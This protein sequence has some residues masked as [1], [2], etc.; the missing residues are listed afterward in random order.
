[1]TD[2]LYNLVIVAHPDDETIYFTAPILKDKTHPWRVICI[3]N[4]NAD[5]NG[6]S[7]SKQFED[8]CI[9]LGVDNFE[10]WD[11]PDIYEERLD[12]NKI[13]MELSE[14]EIPL[15]VYT[16]GVI[17]EYG[18]PHHQD[19]SYAVH[20]VFSKECRVV[21]VSYNTFPDDILK[22]TEEEYTLKTEI[23]SKVYHSEINRFANL[24][25][26]TAIDSYV[27]VHLKEVEAIY[28]F[29]THKVELDISCLDKYKWLAN[30][31]IET[32]GSKNKR[33]F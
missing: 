10:Q 33:L 26:A 22:L 32:L 2:K 3:T 6:H 17:G 9:K 24:V 7:R 19:V 20:K 15:T 1:M 23:L 5:G 29:L 14:F 21:S 25:P 4:G 30:H 31:I 28:N 12:V 16:H 18:H 13:I 8:A 27:E 11:Y